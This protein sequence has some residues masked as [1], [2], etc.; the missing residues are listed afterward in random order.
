MTGDDEPGPVVVVTGASDGIGAAAARR[1]HRSGARVVVVGRSPVKTA[2]VAAELGVE[3]HVCDFARLDDVRAL[4][5]QLLHDHPRI[6]VLAGNAGAARPRR[7]LTVDGNEWTLQV[8]HLAPY[9]LTRLLEQPLRAAGGRVVTTASFVHWLG[10]TRRGRGER[11][12]DTVPYL[13]TR[14]YAKA[15]LA[16]L[17]MTRELARRWAPDVTA[18]CFDP[19]AVATNFGAGAGGVTGLAFR[20]PLTAFF[21]TPAQ[22]ADTLVWLATAP[23]GWRNGAHHAHRAR[24][25]TSMAGRDDRRAA[26]LWDLSARLVGLDP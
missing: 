25:W 26:E 17:L 5:E 22:G 6:D 1:L 7:E 14:A 8:G 23:D 15:K 2:A 24:T 21:R 11:A 20:T 10:G 12:L 19:G 13:A 16:N 9:L 4:A 3:W 18:T